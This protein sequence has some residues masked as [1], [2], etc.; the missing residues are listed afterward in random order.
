MDKELI[1]ELIG[2]AVTIITCLLSYSKIQAL[3]EYRMEQLEKRVDKHNS[4]VERTYK[5]ESDV[6]TCFTK[7]D[8]LKDEIEA[9]KDVK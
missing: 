4:I 7:Y 2:F 8:L 6:T 3:L 5:L 9:L 1:V